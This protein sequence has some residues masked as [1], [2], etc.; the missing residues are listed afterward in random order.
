MEQQPPDYYDQ[1]TGKTSPKWNSDH[2]GRQTGLSNAHLALGQQSHLLTMAAQLMDGWMDGVADP[3][4]LKQRFDF[5]VN[6]I[7][8]FQGTFEYNTKSDSVLS[9]TI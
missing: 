9:E 4:F 6:E 2:M 8:K 1:W 5:F 7:W 3:E